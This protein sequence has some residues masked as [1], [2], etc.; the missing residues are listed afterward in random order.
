MQKLLNMLYGVHTGNATVKK[1]I[2]SNC[3]KMFTLEIDITYM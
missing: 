2:P 3:R 1:Q